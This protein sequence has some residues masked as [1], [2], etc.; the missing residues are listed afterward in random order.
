MI[1][2]I[3][4]LFLIYDHLKYIIFYLLM[5]YYYYYY[6][7]RIDILNKFREKIILLYLWLQNNQ[8]LMHYNNHINYFSYP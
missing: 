3:F 5:Y 2:L 6:L 1:L 4:L 7:Y 8:D